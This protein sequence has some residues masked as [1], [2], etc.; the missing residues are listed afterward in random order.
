MEFEA[1]IRGRRSI[2]AYT[3]RPVPR[4]LVDAI[5]DE[6][7]WAPSSRNTQAW[8]V[9]VVTGA[10]LERFKAEFKAALGR[11]DP[12]APDLPGTPTDDWPQACSTR[13]VALMKT[14]AATLEAAGETSG[15]AASMARMADVFGAPVV[16][17]FGFEDCLSP[18]SAAYDTASLV[19]NV[20]LAA[21]NEGLGTCITTTLVARPHIWR[22]VLPDAGEKRLVVAVALGY[23]DLDDAANSFERS[24]APLSELVTWVS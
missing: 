20:C 3:D 23:P 10:A 22:E 13:A 9:W 12:D 7:R 21:H 24:R 14:R 5:L 17:V 15:P 4:E 18:S 8:N 2:R 16:L 6:A 19:E 11:G 1:V